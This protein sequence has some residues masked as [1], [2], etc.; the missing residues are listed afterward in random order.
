MCVWHENTMKL[1][2]LH[3][4]HATV[5]SCQQSLEYN[6]SSSVNIKNFCNGAKICFCRLCGF[7]QLLFFTDFLCVCFNYQVLILQEKFQRR[8]CYPFWRLYLMKK[9]GVINWK[10][11]IFVFLTV[12]VWARLLSLGDHTSAKKTFLMMRN[13]CALV[14]NEPWHY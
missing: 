4:L 10:F 7:S 14:I 9:I 3:C 1:E 8:F 5:Y 6:V 2:I 13:I 11:L 12:T